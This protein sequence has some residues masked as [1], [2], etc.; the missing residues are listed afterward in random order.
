MYAMADI[1]RDTAGERFAYR[2]FAIFLLFESKLSQA[3]HTK[4][5]VNQ[6]AAAMIELHAEGLMQEMVQSRC[7][8]GGVAQTDR[9]W[10]CVWLIV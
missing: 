3:L 8:C 9:V 10:N 4:K 5:Q 6:A 2:L 1:S 7:S